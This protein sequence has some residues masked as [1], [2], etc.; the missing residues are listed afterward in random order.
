[1]VRAFL[2]A[3]VLASAATSHASSCPGELDVAGELTSDL[4]A[5]ARRATKN[6]L[7]LVVGDEATLEK[8]LEL[9]RSA[10][11][12]IRFETFLLN[13]RHGEKLVDALI[14]RHREGVRVEVL[15]DPNAL[16]RG[17]FVASVLNFEDRNG[18]L[19]RRLQAAGIE[20]REFEKSTM[21]SMTIG[22]RA[23]HAKLLAVDDRV[24]LFGGTNFDDEENHDFNFVVR[25]PGV[26]DFVHHFRDAYSATGVEAAPLIAASAWPV[27]NGSLRVLST[28]QAMKA[29]VL[30][31]IRD[32]RESIWL[33]MYGLT[34]D[35]VMQALVEA[36]SRL[37]S[38]RVRVLLFDNV[39]FPA[40]FAMLRSDYPNA[41]ALATLAS[42]DEP[43]DVRL[44]PS[45]RNGK[46]HSKAM[47]VDGR[48]AYVGSAN[49]TPQEFRTVHNYIGVVEGAEPLAAIRAAFEADWARASDKKVTRLRMRRDSSNVSP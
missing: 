17:G 23:E 9:V 13:G 28:E 5:I 31:A 2:L 8:A 12:V 18:V 27:S 45:P 44:L 35:D 39:N 16:K 40:P 42:V 7:E 19:R 3:A 15:M 48:S 41:G 33:E 29:E 24:A 30:R 25:G 32:A 21:P 38:D 34:D 26:H 11:D 36:R 4:E 14:E 10:T 37:G 47:I 1:M 20:I 43:V 49:Y 6:H 46:V 22:I